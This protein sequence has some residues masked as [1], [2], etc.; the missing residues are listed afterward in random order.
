MIVQSVIE[1]L[2]VELVM[3]RAPSQK[4]RLVYQYIGLAMIGL[5]IIFVFKNDIERYWDRIAGWFTN[6]F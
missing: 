5:L 3:R 4:F 6:L 1:A 2:L